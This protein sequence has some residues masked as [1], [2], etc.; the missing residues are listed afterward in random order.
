MQIFHLDASPKGEWS[1]SRMLARHFLD[2][3]RQ[4]ASRIEVDYLDAVR[5]ALPHPTELYAR[6]IYAPP[7]ARTPEMV[8]CLR[9]SDALCRRLLD[10]DALLFAT[11]MHNF[12]VPVA[13]KAFIDHVVRGGV[14]Y[15]V[16]PDGE[17]VGQLGGK[18]VLFSTTRGADFR[19][20]TGYESY[21]ALTPALRAAFG[22]I[23]V[24]DPAF[25]DAQPLQ[26]A[27]QPA[28]EAAIARAEAELDALADEW[29]VA[30]APRRLAAT[31]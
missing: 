17:Y 30:T 16:T 8:E 12:T 22:F 18:K 26:F 10:A 20:G 14:T 4:S 13:F 23:G 11:P 29:A 3:L 19:P 27:D 9:V 15:R 25:V 31:A 7:E 5:E 21:D 2:R 6:A 28:R 24:S 1:N